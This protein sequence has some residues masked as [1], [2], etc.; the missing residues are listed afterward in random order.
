MSRVPTRVA[1]A[2]STE[3]TNLFESYITTDWLNGEIVDVWFDLGDENDQKRN[4]SVGHTKN[5]TKVIVPLD[6]SLPGTWRRVLVHS[7]HKWHVRGSI[8]VD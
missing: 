6:F 8:V 3:V 2:R 4:Q 5:Y 7:V 1:K